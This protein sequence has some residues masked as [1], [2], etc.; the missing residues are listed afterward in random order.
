MDCG[1]CLKKTITWEEHK[2]EM[3]RI[4]RC[5]ARL[6]MMLLFMIVLLVISWIGFLQYRNKIKDQ[7]IIISEEKDYGMA[8]IFC[9]NLDGHGS[10][11]NN[12]YYT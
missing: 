2:I 5:N 12:N 7:I 10:N 9:P 1:N 11:N 8:E 4:E 3:G 6:S